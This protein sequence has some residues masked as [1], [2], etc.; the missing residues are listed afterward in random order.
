MDDELC[1]FDDHFAVNN[2]ETRSNKLQRTSPLR[3]G[4]KRPPKNS[5]NDFDSKDSNGDNGSSAD[6]LTPAN[7]AQKLSPDLVSATGNDNVSTKLPDNDNAKN[8][9]DV[10]DTDEVRMPYQNWSDDEINGEGSSADESLR[11]NNED[12][13]IHLEDHENTP[14]VPVNDHPIVSGPSQDKPCNS[15]HINLD[16]ST[17]TNND[18]V[19]STKDDVTKQDV[20]DTKHGLTNTSRNSTNTSR[21]STNTS[22]NS[23]NTSRNSTNAK[24]DVIDTN[25]RNLTHSISEGLVFQEQRKHHLPVR[26]LGMRR[27]LS[28]LNIRYS[29]TSIKTRDAEAASRGIRAS[30]VSCINED[31]VVQVKCLYRPTPEISDHSDD[32][33]P[34]N[35]LSTFTGPTGTFAKRVQDCVTKILT[36]KTDAQAVDK[37]ISE[38]LSK[39]LY[40]LLDHGLKKNFLGISLLSAGT[41]VWSICQTVC[42]VN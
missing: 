24:H 19:S 20:T 36:A 11:T 10:I 40:E 38:D 4:T 8:N 25:P 2:D 15:S 22:R 32:D 37:L 17:S 26:H 13:S 16:P 18:D 34:A 9:A 42:K 14:S 21:N 41:N 3:Y 31:E 12:A 1:F 39:I 7:V 29:S 27:S 6:H 30:S 28:D 23:T 35:P 33:C 5:D